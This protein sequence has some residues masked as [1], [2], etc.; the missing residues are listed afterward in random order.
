MSFGIRHQSSARWAQA[1]GLLVASFVLPF[2]ISAQSVHFATSTVPAQGALLGEILN[3]KSIPQMG[4][5]VLLYDRNDNLL[6]RALSTEEGRFAF[7]N[8]APDVYTVRVTLASFFPALRRNI[9]VVAGAEKW[10]QVSLSAVLSSIDVAPATSDKASLMSDEWKWVLRSS[11]STRPVLRILPYDPPPRRDT[12]SKVSDIT[13]VVRF[14]G[15]DINFANSGLQQDLGTAFALETPVSENTKVRVSGSLGY[16]AASGLPSAGF[17]TTYIRDREGT[18]GP[19]VSL[20]VRQAYLPAAINTVDPQNSPTLR[21]ASLSTIDSV[22]LL[23]ALRIEYGASL[24]SITLYGRM[25]YISP[26]A[27]ATY[28]LGSGGMFKAAYSSGFAPTEL[29]TNTPRGQADFS[30]DFMALAQAPRISRR[31]SNASVERAK[32]YEVSYEIV[33]GNRTITV[34]GFRDE[35]SDAA[36][37]MTGTLDL[38]GTD[39]L[40]QDLNSRGTVFNG[41]NYQRTGVSLALTQVLTDFLQIAVAGGRSG[42]MISDNLSVEPGE[43][44]SH[45]RQTQRPWA[46]MR[47]DASLPRT[48]TRLST[49][50][51][52]TD[53]RALMPIHQSLTG[54]SLQQIGWSVSTMQPL[55]CIFGIRMEVMAEV[56]NLLAQGYLTMRDSHGS[57]ASLTNTPRQVR[58]GLTFIF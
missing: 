34:S 40:M 7:A 33:D 46:T 29:L 3:S 19:R 50:Y 51:G 45:I 48:G 47:L 38:A 6:Q 18:S 21:T 35:V 42:A 37:L 17:R 25:N 56:R 30:Q 10:L 13:G 11:Q 26:F 32:S 58:G 44:R 55:P 31:D 12:A 9:T 23:D 14:S 39:N 28:N 53:F 1:S 41:G 16:N 52:W 49:G 43:M 4:A 24:D 22:E 36:F 57:K 5:T 54:R 2:T 27:R 15:G 8:L 20:T